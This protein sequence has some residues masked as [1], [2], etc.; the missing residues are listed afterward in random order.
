MIQRLKPFFITAIAISSLAA[1]KSVHNVKVPEA[2]Q[3]TVELPSK[4]AVLSTEERQTWGHADLA[5]DTIPG[6]SVQKAYQ[7]LEGKKSVPVIVAV[8]DSGIDLRHEDLKEVLWK[9][10][11]EIPDNGIDDDKNGFVDDV[12][13][14]N[15]LGDIY[16]ANLEITRIIREK[17]T[18]YDGVEEDSIAKGDLEDYKYYMELKEVFDEKLHEASEEK[19]KMEFY[20]AMFSEAH[21]IL[22]EKTGK[23]NYTLEDIEPI[24]S[25]DEKLMAAVRLAKNVLNGG[26][27]IPEQLEQV[28][29]GL[30]HYISQV[31]AHYNLDFYPR[32]NLGDNPK[33]LK[34]V[35][36]GDNDPGNHEEDEIHGTHVAGIILATNGNNKGVDGVANNAKLMSV[37][38]VPNGDEYDKDIA[39]GIRYAVDNGAKVINTSFGKG[40]SPNVEW[41]YKAIKY[42]EKHDVLIVNAAGND[43]Q[44][45]DE[46]PTFPND[47][48]DLISEISDNV[49]TVGAMGSSYDENM[50]APFSNY[51]KINVDVFAP[52]VQ[53]YAPVP[54]NAYKYLSGT[55]MAAP[56]TA[57]VATIIRSYYPELSAKQVKYILMNSGTKIEID[58][59]KPGSAIEKVKLSDLCVSGRIV[60][61]YNA[62]VMADA[63]VASKK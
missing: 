46:V 22:I 20:Y 18:K 12:Y 37:R 48:E 27:T 5:T 2:T 55:S 26:S 58:L 31:D 30:A 35:S 40:Y 4:Q 56:S 32:K 13:G 21:Q 53:V 25:T 41:V 19:N 51:G 47:S 38:V 16:D 60:N 33:D 1:C 3:N 8:T 59:L 28:D 44:N 54:E 29:G 57:G 62:V 43:A 39:L 49:L 7:F 34:D 45:I 6:M 24:L 9:N 14:W 36:Y 10:E 63:M 42:A 11:D 17:A 15:F 23:T 61:A 52:G 50:L